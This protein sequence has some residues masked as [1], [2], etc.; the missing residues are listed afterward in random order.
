MNKKEKK[1]IINQSLNLSNGRYTDSEVDT[2]YDIVSSP[3]D[4]DGLSKTKRR[5][6]D[7]W[8]SDGKYQRTEETTFTLKADENGVR[9]DEDYR[10]HDDDG[11][12]GGYNST[13]DTGRDFINLFESLFKE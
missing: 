13:H 2:M 1:E 6:F 4:Y 11:Q 3:S 5:S 12:T 7:G 10:Y 9:I 8:C